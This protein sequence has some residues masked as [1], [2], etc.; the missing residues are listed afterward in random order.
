MFGSYTFGH[1]QWSVEEVTI[2]ENRNR[3]IEI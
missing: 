3:R 1:L 2:E